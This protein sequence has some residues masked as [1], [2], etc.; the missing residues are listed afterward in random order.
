MA[1]TIPSLSVMNKKKL[2]HQITNVRRS[3][4]STLAM[5]FIFSDP[6]KKALQ[7][8]RKGESGFLT[9]LMSSPKAQEAMVSIVILCQSLKFILFVQL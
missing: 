2:D 9:E 6:S 1:I 7:F 5:G 3:S 4:V 8:F